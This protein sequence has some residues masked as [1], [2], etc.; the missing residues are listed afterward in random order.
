[1]E[2]GRFRT[3]RLLEDRVVFLHERGVHGRRIAP[4]CG[5]SFGTVVGIIKDHYLGRTEAAQERAA[6]IARQRGEG[7][8]RIERLCAVGCGRPEEVLVDRFVRA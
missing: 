3:R 8:Q 1:M 6:E 5:V 2:T 7:V 4:H